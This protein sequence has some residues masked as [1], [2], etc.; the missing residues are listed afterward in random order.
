M[1]DHSINLKAMNIQPRLAEFSNE[2]IPLEEI[3]TFYSLDGIKAPEERPYTW[4]M[5]V[6]TLDGVTSFQE[7]AAL[8]GDT[9]ALTHIENSG[10]EADW[11]LL[12]AGWLYADAVLG[13]GRI[14]RAEPE[15]K[16]IPV[17][18]DLME[19]RQKVLKKS[20]PYP[21]NLVIT[22]TGDF[23]MRHPM[24][25]DDR[26]F[27]VILTTKHGRET[28]LRSAGKASSEGFHPMEEGNT[29]LKTFGGATLDYREVMRYLRKEMDI[30]FLDVTAGGRLIAALAKDKLLD[31]CRLTYAGHFGGRY[32]SA[33]NPRSGLFDLS[34]EQ[35]FT[36]QNNPLINYEAIRLHGQHHL[37]LRGSYVYRH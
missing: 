18:K 8:A 37:F 17:Y 7:Q 2:F 29:R 6:A 33:G 15:I 19:Y 14:I 35:Y 22:A 36:P 23:D 9:V 27:T 12:N 28:V 30:R 31:E 11:R 34:H 3:K 26:F 20:G 21:I 1:F 5:S 25:N 10:S 13:T 32:N 4:T 16:W 24:F